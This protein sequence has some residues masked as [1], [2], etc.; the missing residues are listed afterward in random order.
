MIIRKLTPSNDWQFGKGLS[1]YA[2]NEQAVEE[3]I[4][5]RVLSWVGDCPFALPEGVDWKNRLDVGQ[6]A[7][8][9]EELRTIILQSFGVVGVNTLDVQFDGTSR[10]F[11]VTY[12][13]ETIFSAS[14]QRVL[15]Q[16]SGT[17]GAPN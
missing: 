6:K 10:L 4:S 11:T 12:D 15:Q 7:A 17:T 13:V 1:D 9:T 14:F 5:S 8:L 16:A 3:N 2:Q